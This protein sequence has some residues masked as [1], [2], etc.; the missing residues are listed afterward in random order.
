[1]NFARAGKDDVVSRMKANL[2]KPLDRSLQF[3]S[4]S[5]T[6]LLPPNTRSDSIR[7]K[8]IH[9]NILRK[10]LYRSLFCSPL[11]RLSNFYTLG[12]LLLRIQASL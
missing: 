10:Y 1:M 4:H 12:I 3:F 11:S 8:R 9:F 2:L 5:S 6:I 7:L